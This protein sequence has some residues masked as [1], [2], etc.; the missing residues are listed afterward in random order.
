MIEKQL[1]PGLKISEERKYPDRFIAERAHQHLKKLTSFG[2]RVAGSY[3]NEVLAVNFLQEEIGK[4]IKESKPH[5]IIQLDLQNANGSFQLEFLDGMNLVYRNQQN[6]VVKVGSKINS[7]Y[8][9]LINC[10][11][12]SVADSYGE[13]IYLY[14]N[15]PS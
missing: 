15:L 9:L 10:H 3:E 14:L 11:F 8:S 7:S 2:P 6:V 13:L 4:I 1:P 5:N 12:D